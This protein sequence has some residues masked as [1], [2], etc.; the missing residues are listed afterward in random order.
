MRNSAPSSAGS[1]RTT[2]ARRWSTRSAGR[3]GWKLHRRATR[4]AA[5]RSGCSTRLRSASCWCTG[6]TPLKCSTGCA[7]TPSA[8][9]ATPPMLNRE[10]GFEIDVTVQRWRDEEF[11]VVTGTAQPVRDSGVDQASHP[12]WGRRAGRRCDATSGRCFP[13]WDL[14]SRFVLENADLGSARPVPRPP[15]SAVRGPSSTC[16]VGT[17]PRFTTGSGPPGSDSG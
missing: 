4:G 15:T 5:G 2:S 1:D 11:L 8:R 14:V 9:S 17:R 10:G 3:T 16:A 6:A 13:C 7:P 12:G